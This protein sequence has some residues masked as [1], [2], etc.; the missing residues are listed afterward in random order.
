LTTETKFDSEV[1]PVIPD[2][3]DKIELLAGEAC[4]QLADQLVRQLVFAGS[5]LELFLK[6]SQE[7][8]P[9]RVG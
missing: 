3:L 1:A 9:A 2:Q 6:S 4:L 5:P 7:V 8:L